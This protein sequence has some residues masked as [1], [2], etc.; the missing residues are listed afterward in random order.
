MKASEVQKVR[1][2]IA[3]W[4][5]NSSYNYGGEHAMGY[6]MASESVAD[7]VEDFINTVTIEEDSEEKTP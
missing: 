1:E 6:A 2:M 7:E 3:R 5:D 4:R